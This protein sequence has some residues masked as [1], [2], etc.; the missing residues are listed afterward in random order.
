METGRNIRVHRVGTVTFG[1]LMILFGV[2]F[3]AH[4]FLPWLNYE[5][6]V[7]LWPL[8]FIFLGTEV[9]AG[10]HKASKAAEGETVKF[11]YDKTAILLTMVLTFFAMALAMM[12]YAIQWG[13][14]RRGIL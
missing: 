5:W 1:V 12:D 14:W 8:L 4:I 10:N 9:L 7:R 6:I 3:L 2:L 11:V 13:E